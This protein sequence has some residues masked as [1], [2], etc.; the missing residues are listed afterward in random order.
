[1][2]EFSNRLAMI[3]K[4]ETYAYV[5]WSL[6][7]VCCVLAAT[8]CH[9]VLRVLLLLEKGKLTTVWHSA[10]TAA[11]IFC[12]HNLKALKNA[13]LSTLHPA[14]MQLS[15]PSIAKYRVKHDK[16]LRQD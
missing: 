15:A 10:V 16:Q 7:L 3:M 5:L 1:V 4:T 9:D 2:H 8:A 6:I 14:E 11:V 12:H 13:C